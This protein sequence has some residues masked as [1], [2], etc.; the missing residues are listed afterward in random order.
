MRYGSTG[1]SLEI[2]LSSGCIEKT[3]ISPKEFF[4]DKVKD[5]E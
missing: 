5:M 3:E 1:I 4:K 2:D